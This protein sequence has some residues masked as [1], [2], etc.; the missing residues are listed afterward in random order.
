MSP[1]IWEHLG[2]HLHGA[3]ERAAI[4]ATVT[5]LAYLAMRNTIAGRHAAEA[6]LRHAARYIPD[7]PRSGGS[8]RGSRN[9]GISS[10]VWTTPSTWQPRSP[11]ASTTRRT[12]STASSSTRCCRPIPP[13]P[14]GRGAPPLWRAHPHPREPHRPGERG[15]VLARR[16][17]AGQRRR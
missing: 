9:G 2:Y 6:D 1:Y 15:R 10:P 4:L 5:D 8:H 3:G 11:A 16:P 12:P 17:A 14:P 7:T 13:R